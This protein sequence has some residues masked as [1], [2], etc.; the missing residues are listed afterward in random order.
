MFNLLIVDDFQIDRKNIRDILYS[1]HDMPINIAGE[2][3]NGIEVM[4]FLEEN[5]VDIIISDIEMPFMNGLELARNVNFKYPNI[6]IIFCSLYDEFEYARKAL[7]LNTY[8]YILKPIDKEELEKALNSIILEIKNEVGFKKEYE[9]LKQIIE[10]SRPQLINNFIREIINGITINDQNIMD[11]ADYLGVKFVSGNFILAYIEIDNYE[12]VIENKSIEQRQFFTIKVYE[13]L[14]EI[15]R[16]CG[17]YPIVRL[18]DCHFVYLVSGY[19]KSEIQEEILKFSRNVIE[20][21]NISDTSVTI[22]CS[23]ICE[24]VENVKSLYQ[25]CLYIMRY[26]FTLGNGKV[27]KS[28]DI[29]SST[30][31]HDIDINTMQKDIKFLINSGNKEEIISYVDKLFINEFEKV[32]ERY[33]RNLSFSIVIS[34][35]FVFNENNESL[36]SIFKDEKLVWEELLKFETIEHLKIWVKNLLLNANNYFTSKARTKHKIVVEEAKKFIDRNF[37]KGITIETIADELHYSPNYLSYIFKQEVGETIADYITKLKIEKAK[38]MLLDI[39]NKI[40]SV[41]EALGF[42]NTAYFC[43][44][45]KKFTLMTPKE[46]RERH[47]S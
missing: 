7:F 46:Y 24:K 11:K 35:I 45:F 23:D 21:F 20:V 2:C 14:K 19:N 33:L 12:K 25:Q 41:S 4:E 40:Y 8:G 16:S 43:S 44:V 1:F 34:V 47:K 39:R 3:D 27:L 38:N 13:K 6:K 18:D 28:S 31:S 5:K 42:S 29:P 37:A 9:K 22:S 26:K 10:S 17:N 15:S 36:N 30:Y 32:S